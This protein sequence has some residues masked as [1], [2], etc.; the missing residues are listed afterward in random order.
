[1]DVIKFPLLVSV[2]AAREQKILNTEEALKLQ[3]AIGDAMEAYWKYIC[4]HILGGDRL[5]YPNDERLVAEM[6]SAGFQVWLKGGALDQ[7]HPDDDLIAY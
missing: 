6:N 3:N 5:E 4:T 2:E 7:L 1:M